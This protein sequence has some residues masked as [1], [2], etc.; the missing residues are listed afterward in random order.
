MQTWW[1]GLG[2][3]LQVL[4]CIAVPSTLIL[5]L[6]MV[7][8]TFGG[9]GDGGVDISDTSGIDMADGVD[10]GDADLG[11]DTDLDADAVT[12]GGDPADISAFRLLTLQT[13]VTFLAVF[14]WVSIICL[15]AGMPTVG[16]VLV[17]A[18]CGFLMML[19]VAKMVQLSKKLVENGIMDLR[20]AIGETATVYVMIPPKEN[21]T[22]KITMQL[23]GR[24][25]ELD[26][27]NAGNSAIPAGTQVLVTDIIGDSLVVERPN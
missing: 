12:D 8:T 16:G 20:G 7:L 10:L 11:G 9:H 5:L 2:L 4:Y 21:G 27:V 17:G 14:G 19:L 15:N 22:G 24:F 18:V 23:Q 13:V 25:C 1:E 26:A 6:Q 3:T